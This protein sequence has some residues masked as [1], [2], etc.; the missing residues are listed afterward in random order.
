[1]GQRF[2]GV[3]L[4]IITI[5]RPQKDIEKLAFQF[6]GKIAA[7]ASV[8]LLHVKESKK[9][10][11]AERKAEEGRQVLSKIKPDDFLVVLDEKGAEFSTAAFARR[12]EQL[13]YSRKSFVFVVGSDAGL[14][15]DMLNRAQLVLSLSRFTL[16]HQIAL[17]V[18]LEQLYRVFTI[19]AGHP[20]HRA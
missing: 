7:Y 5:G 17:L 6:T 1:M 11:L 3:E 9:R 12:T 18:L 20:Y 2:P 16:A 10:S 13:L 19:F 8:E 15:E 4:K 14:S